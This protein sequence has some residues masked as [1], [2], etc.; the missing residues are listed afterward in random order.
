METFNALLSAVNSLK[1]FNESINVLK[2]TLDKA[3][4]TRVLVI[5]QL[6]DSPSILQPFN[7]RIEGLEQDIETLFE[8]TD[9]ETLNANVTTAFNEINPDILQAIYFASNVVKVKPTGGASGKRGQAVL[10]T[11]SNGT[12]KTFTSG[13][14]AM[15]ELDCASW[16]GIKP[17][18]DSGS[19]SWRAHSFDSK[20]NVHSRFVAQGITSIVEQD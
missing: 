2:E 14:Q 17:N 4:N 9:I 11:W 1:T 18:G 8:A 3:K 6:G 15:A 19:K 7:D 13:S 16:Q 12:S 20:G 5:E 10:V